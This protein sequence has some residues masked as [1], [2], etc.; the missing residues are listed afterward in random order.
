MTLIN[1]QLAEMASS[2]ACSRVIL[3]I[4]EIALTLGAIVLICGRRVGRCAYE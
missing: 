1:C 3:R 4:I 2:N